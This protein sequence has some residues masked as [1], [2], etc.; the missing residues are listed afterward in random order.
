MSKHEITTEQSTRLF[1]EV[2]SLDNFSGKQ[3]RDRITNAILSGDSEEAKRIDSYTREFA[4]P[5]GH[6]GFNIKRGEIQY[7]CKSECVQK[8]IVECPYLGMDI[9]LGSDNER[10][11]VCYHP[12]LQ[13]DNS[14]NGS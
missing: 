8:G 7:L 4:K 6:I 10:V 3:L 2:F 13:K 9:C 5:C 1:E 12:D 11:E 14:K